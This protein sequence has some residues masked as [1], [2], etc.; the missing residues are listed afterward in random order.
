MDNFQEFFKVEEC[1]SKGNNNDMNNC[2]GDF[3]GSTIKESETTA[4][5]QSNIP[6]EQSQ[7]SENEKRCSRES[8]MQEGNSSMIF[9]FQRRAKSRSPSTK[10]EINNKIAEKLSNNSGSNG[11]RSWSNSNERLKES[12]PVIANVKFMIGGFELN[13]KKI[14]KHSKLGQKYSDNENLF[15]NK[16]VD[17]WLKQSTNDYESKFSGNAYDD[18]QMIDLISSSLSKMSKNNLNPVIKS[19]ESMSSKHD[20]DADSWMYQSINSKEEVPV[21]SSKLHN[22]FTNNKENQS[23][24]YKQKQFEL[25]NIHVED[26]LRNKKLIPHRK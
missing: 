7:P 6:T 17:E 15:K 26:F 18:D 19:K 2:F 9:P 16:E 11:E 5:S 21:I 8:R 10:E 20:V 3:T 22:L 14:G 23:P 12:N 4:Q 25:D 13:K 24:N 1:K